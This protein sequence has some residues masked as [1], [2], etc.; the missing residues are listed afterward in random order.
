MDIITVVVVFLALEVAICGIC[1][2]V[3]RKRRGAGEIEQQPERTFYQSTLHP[4]RN[5]RGGNHYK[6]WSHGDQQS[7]RQ[8]KNIHLICFPPGTLP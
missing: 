4:P 3:C 7:N 2:F 6:A 1:C 5:T 8:D